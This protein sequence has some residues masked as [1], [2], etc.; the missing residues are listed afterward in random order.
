MQPRLKLLIS[1]SQAPYDFRHGLIQIAPPDRMDGQIHPAGIG[2]VETENGL[3]LF[4]PR[5]S[6]RGLRQGNA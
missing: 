5:P 6:L 3:R 1:S 2:P 4:F